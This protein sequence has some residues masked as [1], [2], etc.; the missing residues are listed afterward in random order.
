MLCLTTKEHF[1][2]KQHLPVAALC[3]CSYNVFETFVTHIF[4][5][6]WLLVKG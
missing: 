3:S 4:L 2:I 6:I 1:V 5:M